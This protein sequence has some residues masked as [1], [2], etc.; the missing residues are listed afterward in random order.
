MP[1]QAAAP[2]QHRAQR[3]EERFLSLLAATRL[4]PLHHALHERMAPLPLKNPLRRVL[5]TEPLLRIARLIAAGRF[6]GQFLDHRATP[7]LVAPPVCQEA[8]ERRAEVPAQPATRLFRILQRVG[9]QQSQQ[10]IMQRILRVVVRESAAADVSVKRVTVLR[11][12]ILQRPARHL[13]IAAAQPRHE[14]PAR[15]GKCPL[16]LSLH[17]FPMPSSSS[18]SDSGMP[19]RSRYST[20]ATQM[21]VSL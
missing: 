5:L 18:A 20:D 14:R 13:R 12:Q 19:S 4:Q 1:A 2:E 6:R 7:R 15:R 17:F 21:L 11:D 10:E 16:A 8:P 3:R 9:L